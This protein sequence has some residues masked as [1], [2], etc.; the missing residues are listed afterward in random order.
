VG[1]NREPPRERQT[2][3]PSFS[4]WRQ[5]EERLTADIV[6]LALA[7]RHGGH[8]YRKVAELPRSTAG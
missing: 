5:R 8:G 7:R 6:A 2:A 4:L 1:H 3:W